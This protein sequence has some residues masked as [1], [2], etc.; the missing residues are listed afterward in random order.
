LHVDLTGDV[1]PTELEEIRQHLESRKIQLESTG[2]RCIIVTEKEYMLTEHQN[3][4]NS[5]ERLWEKPPN[6]FAGATPVVLRHVHGPWSLSTSH[7]DLWVRTSEHE[8]C[9]R[10]VGVL[11]E[12][13]H[14]LVV[15]PEDA[16]TWLRATPSVRQIR[17][18]LLALVSVSNAGSSD[19]FTSPRQLE[20]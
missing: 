17:G 18:Y 4:K 1:Y 11:W 3:A 15:S 10:R 20:Y 5:I 19:A 13:E 2:E 6:L 8:A 14:E 9:M 7:Y 12:S 16:L